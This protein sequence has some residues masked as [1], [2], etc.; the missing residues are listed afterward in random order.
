MHVLKSVLTKSYTKNRFFT[1]HKN[2]IIIAASSLALFINLIL[3]TQKNPISLS[4]RITQ[5]STSVFSFTAGGDHG[6]SSDTQATMNYIGTSGTNFYLALGDLSYSSITPE[7]AW[8]DWVK[9][10]VGT[11]FP[12]EL[13]SGNHEDDDGPD[14]HIDNFISCLPDR[15]GS[16]TGSYGK[17]YYFDYPVAFPLM[18]VI[19]IGADLLL[20]G[21]VYSYTT[22]NTHY[23]WLANAIDSARASGI[24]WITVTMHKNCITMGIKPTC[25]IGT[26]LMNLLLDKKVDLI[27]QG[28]DHTY[29]RSKQLALSGACTAITVD[30]YNSGCVADDGSDNQYIKSFGSVVVIVGTAGTG[31][32]DVS[33]SDPEAPYFAS[34]MGNNSNPTKG[35]IKIDVSQ[36]Q[37]S[38][39]F[40][41]TAGGTFS[42]SFS[43]YG[44]GV[45]PQPTSIPTPTPGPSQPTPTPTATPVPTLTPTPVPNTVNLLPIADA[46]VRS[47]RASNNYGST[48]ALEADGSPSKIA[49]MKFDTSEFAGRILTSA[50]LRMKVKDKSSGIYNIKSVADVNWLES[51]ITYNN[52]PTP[53]SVVN[54]FAPSTVGQIIES[55]VTS[56]ASTNLG[57]LMSLAIDSVSSD[58]Y[59]FYSKENVADKV[60]LV[61]K[62]Q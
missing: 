39:Q 8:C 30:G 21:G 7:S 44:S 57:Q 42:D 23:N 22:G 2:I 49:Y 60:V 43:I 45:T 31:L 3:L 17:E 33:T 28:H 54:T 11:S 52:K 40:V 47:D 10:R 26:D 51:T 15:I 41:R 56:I 46:H 35:V 14:G 32:Y 25:S 38:A 24:P 13:I 18:R 4:Q 6:G 16:I 19:N 9:Q 5:A 34:W 20:D 61:L 48:T 1:K 58:G 12:F 27:L 62:F 59:D 37:L 50:K 55:D 53:G 29:Q 36:Q